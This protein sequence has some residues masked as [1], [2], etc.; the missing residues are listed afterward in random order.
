[1]SRRLDGLLS[2][3][4]GAETADDLERYAAL[5][6]ARSARD[7]GALRA[8][9]ALFRNGVPEARDELRAYRLVDICEVLL[10]R[11]PRPLSLDEIA[12]AICLPPSRR[13]SLSTTLCTLRRRAA[14]RF[15][16][17]TRRWSGPEVEKRGGDA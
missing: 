4:L 9:A 8:A 12:R 16:R 10:Q 6:E 13:R 2:R 1:M 5:C 15:D 17:R 14:A 11:A 3:V 7:A